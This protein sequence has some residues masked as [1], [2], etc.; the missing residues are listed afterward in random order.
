MS[1]DPITRAVRRGFTWFVMA[2]AII[3]LAFNL[4]LGVNGSGFAWVA[5]ILFAVLAGCCFRSLWRTGR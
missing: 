3:A 5:V 4:W 2:A 1:A